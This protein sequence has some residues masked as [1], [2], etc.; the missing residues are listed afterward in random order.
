VVRTCDAFGNNDLDVA[1]AHE[2]QHRD[3]MARGVFV[4]NGRSI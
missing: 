2:V 1:D 3:E 4:L